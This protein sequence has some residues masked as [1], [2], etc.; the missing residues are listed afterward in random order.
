[1]S[2]E[3]APSTAHADVL[4]MGHFCE[5]H[6]PSVVFVT[7]CVGTR[8]AEHVAAYGAA[9]SSGNKSA[10]SSSCAMCRSFVDG[11]IML[12]AWNPSLTARCSK[13]RR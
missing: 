7:E 9:S 2:L 3:S 5:K 10:T 4:C 11:K 12:I 8:V 13:V 1:M 6:G